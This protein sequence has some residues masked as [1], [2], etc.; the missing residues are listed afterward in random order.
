MDLEYNLTLEATTSVPDYPPQTR[1][2]RLRSTEARQKRY[3][4]L[5]ST[6]GQKI[7]T[8]REWGGE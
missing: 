2:P 4:A 1:Y 7:Y 8:H 3:H 6:L 5:K